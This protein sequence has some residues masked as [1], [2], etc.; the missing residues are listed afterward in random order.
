M[1]TPRKCMNFDFGTNW[2]KVVHLINVRR[3][4]NFCRSI[5]QHS[6]DAY[7]VKYVGKLSPASLLCPSTAYHTFI[8][9][10]VDPIIQRQDPH[11]LTAADIDF[12]QPR[13]RREDDDEEDHDEEDEEYYRE[14]SEI[15]TRVE[16]ALGYN[17][18]KHQDK[19]A[20]YVAFKRCHVWNPL[21]GLWFAR[22]VFPKDD[23]EIRSSEQHTTVYCPARHMVFDI[24]YWAL[25][26]RLEDHANGVP[27]RSPDATFGGQFAF[28]SSA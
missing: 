10:L 6:R 19:L 21:F 2:H 4:D 24:L 25:D 18:E 20:F 28:E 11:Y 9:G 17:Y 22:R 13:P 15:R 23:W 12:L 14:L 3:V 27:Y 5:L 26:D 16:E 1:S 7:Y 8:D